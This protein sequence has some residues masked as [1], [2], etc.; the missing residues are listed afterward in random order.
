MNASSWK[1]P[2][3]WCAA[4]VSLVLAVALVTA[5]T[6]GFGGCTREKPV[7]PPNFGDA[8]PPERL[9]VPQLPFTDVTATSGIRFQHTNGAFGRK[10]LPETMGGGVAVLD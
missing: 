4:V 9:P 2:R 3:R 1:S 5:L 8:R 6:V 10:L 7:E